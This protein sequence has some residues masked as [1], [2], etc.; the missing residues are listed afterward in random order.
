[1]PITFIEQAGRFVPMAM[2]SPAPEHNL[3]IGPDGQWLGEALFP[4]RCGA[5][6]SAW[7]APQVQNSLRC[8]SMRTAAS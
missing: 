4:P 8:A 3:F 1:M 2:M 5:I 7:F 6:R